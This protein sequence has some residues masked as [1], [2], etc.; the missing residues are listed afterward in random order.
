M[1]TEQSKPSQAVS[2]SKGKN[3][4][5][6]D[7]SVD[8]TLQN[9]ATASTQDIENASET[10][11]AMQRREE[12]MKKINV[13][14]KTKMRLEQERFECGKLELEMQMKEL[15]TKYHLLEEE[16]DLERKMRGTGLEIEDVRSPNQLLLETIC[17]STGTKKRDVSDSASRIENLLI[18]D[19]STARFKATPHVNRHSHSTRYRSSQDRFSSVEDRDVFPRAILRYNSGYS[20]S[21]NL[22]KPK[23]KLNNF[24]GNPSN[25]RSG[26]ICSLL[27]FINNHYQTQRG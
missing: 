25:G 1:N 6:T 17:P 21:S 27:Q 15:A 3:N 13:E 14:I 9:G 7:L 26:Q 24:D 22:P 18:A 20:G 2:D 5:P 4:Y 12:R 10:S 23:L 16:R 11:S 8:Q 19:R